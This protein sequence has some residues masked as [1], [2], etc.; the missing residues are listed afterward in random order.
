[1]KNR[2]IISIVIFLSVRVGYSQGG[3]T[4]LNTGVSDW[5]YSVAFFNENTGIVTGENLILR[6]TNGGLNWNSFHPGTGFLARVITINSNT[7]F[8]VGDSGRVYKSV[9]AGLNWVQLNVGTNADIC[10]IC[11][12]NS[13]TGFCVGSFSTLL[14]T[15]NGGVNWINRV[16]SV[17]SLSTVAFVDENSGIVGGIDRYS[18]T[19][20]GT[21]WIP[22]FPNPAHTYRYY[23]AFWTASTGPW[24]TWNET[25][26]TAPPI[27]YHSEYHISKVNESFSTLLDPVYCI[28]PVSQQ[29]VY[30]A[31]GTSNDGKIYMTTNTGSSWVT[32]LTGVQAHFNGICFLNDTVGY[33]AGINGVIYKTTTGGITSV[34]SISNVIPEYFSLSQNYPNPFNPSTKIKFDIPVV[35]GRDRSVKLLIYDILGREVST[36][37]NEQLKPGT[38]EVDWDGSNYASGIYFYSLETSEFTETKKMILMK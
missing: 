37:V 8:V 14:I 13:S 17:T 25:W 16:S 21:S 10:D 15:T 33:A 9:N 23:K 29:K 19:N 36:L 6:T 2:V 31:G 22:W 11:F 35:N 34:N 32:Q 24:I 18:T 28:Y 3:W 27:A 7:S 20:Q 38:Y 1:M 5:F 12:I 4:Q 26:Y 30:A